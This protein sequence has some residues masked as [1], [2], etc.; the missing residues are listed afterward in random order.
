MVYT[1]FNLSVVFNLHA[2]SRTAVAAQSPLRL[3]RPSIYQLL[4]IFLCVFVCQV[5]VLTSAMKN[6]NSGYGI[7]VN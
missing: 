1:H 2:G 6:T 5:Y 3:S 4:Q 7:W